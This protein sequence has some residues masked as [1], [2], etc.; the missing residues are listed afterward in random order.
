MAF[1]PA[2][3]FLGTHQQLLLYFF[4][5]WIFIY[6]HFHNFF[7]NDFAF[8]CIIQFGIFCLFPFFDSLFFEIHARAF[9]SRGGAGE[10]G[11]LCLRKDLGRYLIYLF[12]GFFFW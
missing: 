6:K 12:L 1:D 4:K 7:V 8:K 9:L 10:G 5:S 11:G 3:R 2:G